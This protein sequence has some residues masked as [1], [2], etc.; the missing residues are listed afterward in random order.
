MLYYHCCCCHSC[1]CSIYVS[2]ITSTHAIVCR[3]SYIY[4]YIYWY[5]S[6]VILLMLLYV[7]YV[8]IK[9]YTINYI[10]YGLTIGVVHTYCLSPSPPS[11]AVDCYI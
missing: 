6:F 3:H 8:Y 2:I 11:D 7:V 5:N 10:L 4:I 9:M 1:C